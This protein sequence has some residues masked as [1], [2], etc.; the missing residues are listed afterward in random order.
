MK[1][2]FTL[3]SLVLSFALLA[4]NAGD[5]L[6]SQDVLH[7]IR[8][9]SPSSFFFDDLVNEYYAGFPDSYQYLPATLMIDGQVMDSVGVRMKGGLSFF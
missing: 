7:E 6:F 2:W 4:Q 5:Q 3:L 8:I 1:C 9:E